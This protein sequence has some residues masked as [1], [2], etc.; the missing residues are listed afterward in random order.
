MTLTGFPNSVPTLQPSYKAK[1]EITLHYASD[2]W[3]RFTQLVM[4]LN[5]MKWYSTNGS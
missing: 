3:C 4:G 5:N 1:P 2:W